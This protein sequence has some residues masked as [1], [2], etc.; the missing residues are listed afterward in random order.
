M[1]LKRRLFN[2]VIVPTI[3]YGAETWTLTRQAETRLSTTQ[4]R[5]ERRMTRSGTF[6][7]QLTS[8]GQGC[9]DKAA[10]AFTIWRAL[11]KPAA[12]VML[13]GSSCS[14]TAMTVKEFLSKPLLNA[15]AH[16]QITQIFDGELT[17]TETTTMAVAATEA[18]ILSYNPT[19]AVVWPRCPAPTCFN[20]NVTEQ[21]NGSFLCGA[22]QRREG[23][24]G[25]YWSNDVL[26][27]ATVSVMAVVD[28]RPE[29][30]DQY[31]IFIK[32]I[33]KLVTLPKTRKSTTC[34]RSSICF[35]SPSA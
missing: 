13:A 14:M 31:K 16:T 27:S 32:G 4:R 6:V 3:P 12:V 29:L 28:G 10:I 8:V 18:E 7:D 30:F 25:V 24:G 17:Q 33:G 1:K 15:N 23:C 35:S 9:S 34:R 21:T 20:K 11:V 5:M 22:S 26:V 19:S 2:M